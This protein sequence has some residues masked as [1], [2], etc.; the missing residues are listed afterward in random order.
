MAVVSRFRDCRVS[1]AFLIVQTH[2]PE[3][4]RIFVSSVQK[5]LELE[6][7][8]V[9][10]L[11]TTDP[12]LL[13]HCMPVLF[14]Q[15][16]P[17]PHP[18]PQPYLD[19]LRACAVYVLLLANDYGSLDGDVSATHHEY[20]LA[21][22][23]KLPTIVFLKDRPESSGSAEMKAFLAEIKKTGHTY[24]RFHDREDLKPEILRALVRTL[25]EDFG[26]AA[27]T[28][29]VSEGEHLIEAASA[30]ETTMLRDVPVDALDA[31]LMAAFNRDCGSSRIEEVFGTGYQ[32]LHACGLAV[33][34]ESPDSYA[35]TAAAFVLFGFRPADRFPQCQ[36]LV[37]AYDGTRITGRPK[38]QLNVN[39]ALPRT[40]EEVLRFI[41]AHTFHPHR[42]VGL[43]NLRLEEYPVPALREALVN[44]LA[45]RSYDDASR[46][47]SVRVFS[48]RIEIASPGYPPKPLTISKLQR[49]GYRPC[50]RNPLI[51][52]T[53]A[54]MHLMEQ[55]GS[56]FARMEEAMLN[57]GLE[58]PKLNQQDG[59]F[60]VTLPGPAGNYDRLKVP[61][62]MTG[63][64]TPAVEAKLN[65]RQ[66]TIL[67]HVQKTGAVTSG[68]CRK[69]FGVA[70]LTVHRDLTGLV[71]LKLLHPVGRGRSTRYEL[72][73]AAG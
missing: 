36:V 27:T 4:K 42:V 53:L 39:A 41:D 40:L 25:K 21:Q 44:A 73:A 15:E 43:N 32:T 14:D 70:Y 61:A 67:A 19:A 45:H 30:F 2:M 8:A 13:Q 54:T 23:L 37:D 59:Y 1:A 65:A 18:A 3:K 60:V 48:D 72:S 50:S 6:R 64:V 69:R 5:E 49:G 16:P 62:G 46:K 12:F 58:A 31:E 11:I 38:G 10:H 22:K 34:I 35:A 51:A 63:P 7:A 33:P 55:R 71:A 29:E 9:A 17:P 24:K 28:N 68:W 52:Q 20:R 66:K 47:V 26:I 57:H 56:G